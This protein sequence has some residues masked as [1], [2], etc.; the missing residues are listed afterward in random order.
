[1]THGN[2]HGLQN[3]GNFFATNLL[4][5]DSFFFRNIHFDEVL[6]VWMNIAMWNTVV[7]L[8]HFLD[9]PVTKV[10]QKLFM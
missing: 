9:H 8:P 1:M 10:E 6:Y 3:P 4:D 7:Y 2:Y 5:E